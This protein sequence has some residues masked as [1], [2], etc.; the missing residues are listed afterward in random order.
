MASEGQGGSR[1]PTLRRASRAVYRRALVPL[2]RPVLG[3]AA[4]YLSRSM[5]VEEV[6]ARQRELD[7]R[8]RRQEERLQKLEQSLRASADAIESIVAGMTRQLLR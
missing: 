1:S 6:L 5:Q 2:A 8:F 7:E 3:R 4:R